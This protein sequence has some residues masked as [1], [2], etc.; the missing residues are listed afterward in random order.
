ME[1]KTDILGLLDLT[2]HPSFCVKDNIILKTNPAA[3]GFLIEPGTSMTD[4]VITGGEELESLTDGCICLQLQLPGGSM[5]AS[6]TRMDEYLVFVLDPGSDDAVS[7]A[8]ALTARELRKPLDTVMQLTDQ[9]LATAGDDTRDQTARLNRGLYQILR[10]VGNLSY[11][12]GSL[13]SQEVRDVGAIVD[14]VVEKAR[15]LISGKNRD[16]TYAG[17]TRSVYCLVDAELLERALLNLISNAAKFTPEGGS[18]HIRFSLTGRKLRLQ[19][20]D[21]GSGIADQV[22]QDLFYRHLRQPGIED[23]RYGLGLGMVLVRSCAVQH[24]GVVLAD[25]SED[26]GSRITMTLAIRQQPDDR[27]L[28]PRYLM[29]DYTGGRDHALV[30]LSECLDF[31]HYDTSK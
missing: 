27:L 20:C 26:G 5:P 16:I 14:E 6:V 24:G 3:R 29:A 25:R 12:A 28:S 1:E 11:S 17:L 23:A 7:N 8:L 21:S 10:I 31:R 13:H 22:K 9:L 4:L 19:V 15:M 2:A 18:I 30:E